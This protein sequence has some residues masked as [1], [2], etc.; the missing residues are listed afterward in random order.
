VEASGVPAWE[1]PGIG[2]ADLEA[3]FVVPLD[4]IELPQAAI[5]SPLELAKIPLF[6]W[7][8]SLVVLLIFPSTQQNPFAV[9]QTRSAFAWSVEK[10]PLP[11]SHWFWVILAM[12]PLLQQ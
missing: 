2:L 5:A 11:L 6:F 4:W 7:H 10:T 3:C 12:V 9:P 8:R 1:T